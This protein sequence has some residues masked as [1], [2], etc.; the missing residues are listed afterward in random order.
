MRI[1]WAKHIL[2][3]FAAAC[4]VAGTAQPAIASDGPV[5]TSVGC[6]PA[7]GP[8]PTFILVGPKGALHHAPWFLEL[9]SG[10][11]NGIPLITAI[12][13]V[14]NKGVVV[15]IPHPRWRV[16]P[17]VADADIYPD[18]PPFDTSVMLPTLAKSTNYRVVLEWNNDAESNDC[19]ILE[20]VGEFTTGP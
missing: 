18:I 13:L 7:S 1:L 17:R 15:L 19:P 8:L 6:T 5:P 3:L 16:T 11:V 9:G 4:L 12:E 2:Q 20:T 14:P 10:P